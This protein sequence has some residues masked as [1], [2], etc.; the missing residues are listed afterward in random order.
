MDTKCGQQA[1][2]PE[3]QTVV[4]WR[5]EDQTHPGSR[6]ALQQVAHLG[7]G[8]GRLCWGPQAVTRVLIRRGQGDFPGSPGVENPWFHCKGQRF[9][10]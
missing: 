10:P 2:K 7:W 1:M 8:T 9:D 5:V 4:R 6:Q 3:K